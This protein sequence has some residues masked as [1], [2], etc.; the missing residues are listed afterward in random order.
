MSAGRFARSSGDP[1]TDACGTDKSSIGNIIIVY[2]LL[3]SFVP[4]SFCRLGF[5]CLCLFAFDLMFPAV[6]IPFVASISNQRA[7]RW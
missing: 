4:S 2:V 6:I 5:A 3:S 1:A 7:L